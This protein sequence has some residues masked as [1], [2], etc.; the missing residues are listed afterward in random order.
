M[1]HAVTLTDRDLVQQVD[2]QS[3]L[4]RLIDQ[5]EPALKR[6]VSAYFEQEV[7][8]EDL[9]QEIVVALWRAIPAFHGHSSERTWLYRIAHN[10]AISSAAKMRRRGLREKAMDERVDHPCGTTPNA[11]QELLRKEKWQQLTDSVRELPILDR[12][13]ILLHLDGFSY[14]QIEEVSGLSEAAVASRLTR[15]RE[16]VR[17]SIRSKEDE[18]R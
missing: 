6:L 13:I 9:F 15:I 1:A 2:H 17:K 14:S 12:Q 5:Y 4:T 7:D 18:Q 11:E 8:R 16:R 10:V 3:T